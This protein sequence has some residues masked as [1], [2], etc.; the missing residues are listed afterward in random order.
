MSWYN[1]QNKKGF[2]NTKYIPRVSPSSNSLTDLALAANGMLKSPPMSSKSRACLQCRVRKLGYQPRAGI[3]VEN[4]NQFFM[5]LLLENFG[6]STCKSLVINDIKALTEVLV[7]NDQIE[8]IT[9]RHSTRKTTCM[10]F[11]QVP[12]D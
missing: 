12:H 7:C 3:T 10:R 9:Q 4:I 1:S 6:E 8:R 5:G 11:L 2:L